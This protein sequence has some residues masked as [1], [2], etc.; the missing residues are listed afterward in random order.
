[1]HAHLTC[2]SAADDA[3]IDIVGERGKATIELFGTLGPRSANVLRSVLYAFDG[4]A[5]PMC[6]DCA[7]VECA[8]EQTAE[9]LVEAAVRRR[10][11]N[12]AG[13]TVISAGPEIRRALG[14]A[15]ATRV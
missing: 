10:A 1:M 11:L 7:H 13:V 8:C 3:E 9:V 12:L 14:S 2:N 15:V 5:A 6:V 4:M